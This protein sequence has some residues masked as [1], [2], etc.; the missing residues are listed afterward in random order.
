MIQWNGQENTKPT[1]YQCQQIFVP[2]KSGFWIIGNERRDDNGVVDKLYAIPADTN[3]KMNLLFVENSILKNLTYVGP[4]F[5]STS[6][7][8][9]LSIDRE[10]VPGL[11]ELNQL[12]NY[13]PIDVEELGGRLG[14][15][16]FQDDC[17]SKE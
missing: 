5:I 16:A 9:T 15:E 13:I 2:R 7:K 10:T 8:Y 14:L 11:Y 4:D 3:L 6:N 17:K 12:D 1:I